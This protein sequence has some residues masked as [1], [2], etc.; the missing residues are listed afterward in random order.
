MVDGYLCP[1]TPTGVVPRRSMNNINIRDEKSDQKYT[2]K[3][4]R[5]FGQLH[6]YILTSKDY[7][8]TLTASSKAIDRSLDAPSALMV[9]P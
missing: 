6:G 7:F 1:I 4:R 8:A 9:T 3:E 5:G 2:C